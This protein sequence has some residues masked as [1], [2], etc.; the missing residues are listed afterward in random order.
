LHRGLGLALVLLLIWKQLVV[1]AS[2]RRRLWRRPWDRSVLIGVAS[3]VALLGSVGLGLAWTLDLVS[4]ESFGGYSAL[5][6]HVAL[7]LAVLPPMLIHLR[8][9]W[10]RKP[11]AR[12]LVTR[13]SALRLIGI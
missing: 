6:L 9:R 5:N 4:F 2:L 13:R 8:R 10:E 1:R 11:A 3:G 7:G 12:E